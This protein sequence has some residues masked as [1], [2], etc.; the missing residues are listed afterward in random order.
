MGKIWEITHRLHQK[1]HGLA[2]PHRLV[3]LHAC[4]WVGKSYKKMYC[5]QIITQAC[6]LRCKITHIQI[7]VIIDTSEGYKAAIYVITRHYQDEEHRSK[8]SKRDTSISL[9]FMTRYAKSH[10]HKSILLADR[11]CSHVDLAHRSIL[12]AFGLFFMTRYALDSSFF[13]LTSE[14]KWKIQRGWKHIPSKNLPPGRRKAKGSP[15]VMEKLQHNVYG[16]LSACSSWCQEVLGYLPTTQLIYH[17]DFSS[18]Y[19]R[20]MSNPITHI[21]R[22]LLAT[23]R[24]RRRKKREKQNFVPYKVYSLCHSWI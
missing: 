3:L 6:L 17:K 16:F 2:S 20:G 5:T 21:K 4:K 8:I 22:I 10:T 24:S 12:L 18:S 14:H 15:S 23:E 13:M 1:R 9:F 11:S 7:T 19:A